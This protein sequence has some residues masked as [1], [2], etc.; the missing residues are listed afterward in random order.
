[1]NTSLFAAAAAAAVLVGSPLAAQRQK[2]P[3]VACAPRAM[4]SDTAAVVA[5]VEALD[6]VGAAAPS[7]E[8]QRVLNQLMSLMASRD[9]ADSQAAAALMKKYAGG[10]APAVPPRN[11]RCR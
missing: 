9:D 3:A 4:S 1:M 10:R 8:A 6:F 11:P 5:E 2:A 7:A